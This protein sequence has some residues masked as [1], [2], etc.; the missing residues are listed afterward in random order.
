MIGNEASLSSAALRGLALL[1]TPMLNKGTAFT[2]ADRIDFGLNGLL[3]PQVRH[4]SS[5]SLEPIARIRPKTTTWSATS[6]YAL[7]RTGTRSCF[8]GL[9]LSISSK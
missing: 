4:S 1:D 2:E 9:C 3:P 6:I 7:C 5:S 8:T